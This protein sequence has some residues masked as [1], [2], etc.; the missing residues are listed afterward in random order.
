MINYQ[1][2]GLVRFM[3][4]LQ[5]QENEYQ[6][7]LT[8]GRPPNILTAPVP[9]AVP[10]NVPYED[11]KRVTGTFDY[12]NQIATQLE[13][14]A[15]RDRVAEFKAKA[16]FAMRLDVLVSELRVLRETVNS[17]LNF[18]YFYYY[19]EDKA[20]LLNKITHDW[21]IVLQQFKTAKGDI[22][23]AVDC[24]ALNHGTASVFH[25]MRIAEHGLRALARERRVKL[26]KKQ[27]LEWA[28]WRTVIGE[29]GK[30]VDQIA[31]KKRGPARD[32]ALEF[33]RGAL[34][35]FEGFKDAYR[36]N[37]MHTR[38]SYDGAEALVLMHHVR[39][40]MTR[41]S[42]KIEETGKKQIKWGIG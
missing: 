4:L 17:G 2:F 28:D 23:A 37:V 14:P 16:R 13:L 40:F 20:A 42:S 29:I 25:L 22:C 8:T 3:L 1:V 7:W 6:T 26:P 34:A 41:L 18:R 32:A 9:G 12:A 36:N 21:G 35:S 39:D 11:I 10:T 38:K 33:Y 15:V 31:N 24:F 19:P 30:K 5:L 27:V